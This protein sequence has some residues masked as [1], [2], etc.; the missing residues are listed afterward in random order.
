MAYIKNINLNNTNYEIIAD[1]NH[2]HKKL[3][4]EEYV[5]NLVNGAPELLNTLDELAAAIGDDLNFSVTIM[6][7]INEKSGTVLKNWTAAD[8]VKI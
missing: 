7:L 1:K 5:A 8:V 6:N 4:T 3:A 2:E